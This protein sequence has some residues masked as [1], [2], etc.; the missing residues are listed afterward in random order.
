[1]I[2]GLMI[3]SGCNEKG[4]EGCMVGEEVVTDIELCNAILKLETDSYNEGKEIGK[5]IG[6]ECGTDVR[7]EIFESAIEYLK[8]D[9]KETFSGC[10]ILLFDDETRKNFNDDFTVYDD[11]I[12]EYDIM[13]VSLIDLKTMSEEGGKS[14][15][16]NNEWHNRYFVKDK[17][18]VLGCKK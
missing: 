12:D 10:Y 1:M 18:I 7:Q 9:I 11:G 14:Q 16:Y 5:E 4:A 15:L 17:Y 2:L 3:F 8:D 6:E 13:W